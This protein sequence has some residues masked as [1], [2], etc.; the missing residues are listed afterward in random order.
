MH[1][2]ACT[3]ATTF[4]GQEPNDGVQASLRDAALFD[5]L[6]ADA[7]CTVAAHAREPTY[8][9]LVRKIRRKSVEQRHKASRRL[10]EITNGTDLY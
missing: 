2:R 7:P 3:T 9:L 10:G 8:A 4:V 1:S 6:Y 5:L